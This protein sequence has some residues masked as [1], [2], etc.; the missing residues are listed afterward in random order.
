[1]DFTAFQTLSVSPRVSLQ[2]GPPN[3]QHR[4][5]YLLATH[6]C[7]ASSALSGSAVLTLLFALF[8]GL[9]FS[10]RSEDVLPA[11]EEKWVLIVQSTRH[12]EVSP[13]HRFTHQEKANLRHGIL[14]GLAVN[15]LIDLPT[16][17]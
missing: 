7:G 14:Y 2:V 10:S 9:A 4:G 1:M 11:R 3:V 6:A 15:E 12:G 8:L 13:L 17:M 16:E 5:T